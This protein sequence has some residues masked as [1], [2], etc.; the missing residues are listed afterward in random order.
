[1][2]R[3]TGGRKSELLPS[4]DEAF[5]LLLRCA[6]LGLLKKHASVGM[7]C[8]ASVSKRN[9]GRKRLKVSP[10]GRLVC[11]HQRNLLN[12]LPLPHPSRGDAGT[13]S[14]D[15]YLQGEMC[16]SRNRTSAFACH[17]D[18]RLF[19]PGRQESDGRDR[20]THVMK[21]IGLFG[22]DTGIRLPR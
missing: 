4:A 18:G 21:M 17:Q 1:M 8:G 13:A 11:V 22:E 7:N 2:M 14:V 6:L 15:G 5:V 3:V 10:S 9:G 12:P 20:M 19:C 16:G